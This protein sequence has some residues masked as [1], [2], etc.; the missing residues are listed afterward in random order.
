MLSFAA[1][2]LASSSLASHKASISTDPSLRAASTC[3]GPMKPVPMIPALIVPINPNRDLNR[4]LNRYPNL[5]SPGPWAIKI[6]I[7][8]TI[9]NWQ[10]PHR[11]YLR[12]AF[13][14]LRS[15]DR[16][17]HCHTLCP[18]Q[19][20][21]MNLRIGR[22]G[23]DK[24]ID[25]VDEGVFITDDVTGRPPGADVRMRRLRTQNRLEPR[26][27]G[28]ITA[29]AIFQ[30]VHPLETE[31]DAPLGPVDF[32]AIEILVTWRQAR[33]LERAVRALGH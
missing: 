27:V 15:H 16:L 8:I 1:L 2:A 30:L 20:I 19:K 13:F 9:M 23:V 31:G 14:L 10:L 18:I 4:N 24:V 29:V 33:G 22:N 5:D 25:G 11:R 3:A 7:R 28:R 17:E 12:P 32:P 26:L 21:R 6:T